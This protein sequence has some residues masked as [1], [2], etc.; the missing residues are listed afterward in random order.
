MINVGSS[1]KGCKVYQCKVCEMWMLAAND[2]GNIWVVMNN[3]IRRS[4]QGIMIPNAQQ[5]FKMRTPAL[6][7]YTLSKLHMTSQ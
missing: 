3:L 5:D 2:Q 6:N 4:R 1:M 7:F